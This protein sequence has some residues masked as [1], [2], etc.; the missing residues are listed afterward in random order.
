MIME[1]SPKICK[2]S[3]SWWPG[4]TDNLVI[5]ESKGLRT[6]RANG[7]QPESWQTGDPGRT[8]VPIVVQ[9]LGVQGVEISNIWSQRQLGKKN[10]FLFR[11]GQPPFFIQTW[12]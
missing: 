1:T 4:R 3:A 5:S 10:S 12:N 8:N 6:R 11:G 2:V 9:R 7:F